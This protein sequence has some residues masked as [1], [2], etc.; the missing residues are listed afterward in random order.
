[1]VPLHLKRVLIFMSLLISSAF[2]DADKGVWDCGSRSWMTG[3]IKF[4]SYSIDLIYKSSCNH[5]LTGDLLNKEHR[6]HRKKLIFEISDAMFE[7]PASRKA[8]TINKIQK[9]PERRLT[10][11]TIRKPGLFD[12]RTFYIVYVLSNKFPRCGTP[13]VKYSSKHEKDMHDCQYN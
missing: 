13:T 12:R 8:K 2:G 6:A 1:M 11:I 9:Y 4:P 3:S 10:R 7:F 5:F